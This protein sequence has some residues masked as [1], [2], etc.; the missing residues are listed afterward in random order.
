MLGGGS[1]IKNVS[2]LGFGYNRTNYQFDQ[3]QRWARYTAG[4]ANEIKRFGMFRARAFIVVIV[5]MSAR[6]GTVWTGSQFE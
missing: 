4:R 5:I 6:Q 1:L 3:G 2:I